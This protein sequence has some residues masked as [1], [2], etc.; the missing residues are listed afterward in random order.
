MATALIALSMAFAVPEPQASIDEEQAADPIDYICDAFKAHPIVCLAE[1]GHQSKAPHEF[2]RRLLG[3][4]RLIES[5]DV[6]I[7]EFANARYQSVLDAYIRG[8]EVSFDS[9]SRVWRNTGQSPMGPWD[10][11]VY[12]RL[13]EVIRQG[14]R[15]LPDSEKVQVLAGDPFIDWS[16]IETNVDFNAA[17]SPRDPYVAEQAIEFA[18]GKGMNVLIIFGGAHLPKVPIAQDDPRNSL[19]YRILVRHPKAVTAI[20]FLD[21][22]N[23]G[24]QD[25]IGELIRGKVYSTDEQW[26]GAVN[27]GNY[28]PEIFSRVTDEQTGKQSWQQVRLYTDYSIEDLFDALIYIGPSSEWGQEPS[29]YDPER[30][31]E[32]LD[33]LDRRSML[34]FNRPFRDSQ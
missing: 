17:R 6:I 18:F 13:L 29:A 28:L 10:S 2:L 24:V 16:L 1:G 8:E 22:W 21:P 14:N 15:L 5:V 11:P 25:R 31:A 3:D 20:G 27:G 32:Y 23:L 12:H 19:S 34:R 9:L 33:E 7:V 26:L 4:S 30:D